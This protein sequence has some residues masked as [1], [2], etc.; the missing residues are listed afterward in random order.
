MAISQNLQQS[1]YIK[2]ILDVN[3][4]EK[5]IIKPVMGE[6][7][8][9]FLTPI[10]INSTEPV[11]SIEAGTFKFPVYQKI[12][13]EDRTPNFTGIKTSQPPKVREITLLV[14]N[15]KKTATERMYPDQDRRYSGD[16]LRSRVSQGHINKP[17]YEV[18]RYN[19]NKLETGAG[20]VIKNGVLTQDQAGAEKLYRS[21]LAAITMIISLKGLTTAQKEFTEFAE[22][23]LIGVIDFEAAKLLSTLLLTFGNSTPTQEKQFINGMTPVF[24]IS[25]VKFVRTNRFTDPNTQFIVF[26]VGQNGA[27][28]AKAQ[29]KPII[30]QGAEDEADAI[31]ITTKYEHDA[32]VGHNDLVVLGSSLAA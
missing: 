14:A 12:T 4:V 19:L 11:G 21:I 10:I 30:A 27:L 15:Y 13:V 20:N 6:N 25:G 8:I 31:V 7:G 16:T 28:M 17:Y 24:T 1:F 32:I 18:D 23:E 26:T 2:D 29:F 5:M 9:N 3:V 22:N